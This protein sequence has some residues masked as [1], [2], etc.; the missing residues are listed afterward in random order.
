VRDCA[1]AARCY[2]GMRTA[3][4]SH[5]VVVEVSLLCVWLLSARSLSMGNN[6]LVGSVPAGLTSRF[7]L[8]STAWSGNCLTN[9][10]A[11]YA[12]CDMPERAA[13]VDI[14]SFT[15]GH[16]WV[17]GA[18]WLSSTIHPCSW[19]GVGCAVPGVGPVVS[20][21]LPANGLNGTLPSTIRALTALT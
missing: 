10:T 9:V 5:C 13:L 16:E 21:S 3:D 11:R 14:F 17:V 2:P 12:A 7:P 20:L 19:F 4:G 1:H 15:A 6:Q 18:N 8:S